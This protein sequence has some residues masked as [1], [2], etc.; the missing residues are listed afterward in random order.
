MHV[1]SFYQWQGWIIIRTVNSVT[2]NSWTKANDAASDEGSRSALPNTLENCNQTSHQVMD[3]GFAECAQPSGGCQS[4]KKRLDCSGFE[5]CKIFR[6]LERK[7]QTVYCAD[8]SPRE[9]VFELARCLNEELRAHEDGV[10]QH[11]Q[12]SKAATQL[13]A[14]INGAQQLASTSAGTK[15]GG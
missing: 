15:A 9:D 14:A 11:Q 13:P 12:H 10:H 1:P 3:H 4:T 5:N 8:H 7:V 6:Q 2:I